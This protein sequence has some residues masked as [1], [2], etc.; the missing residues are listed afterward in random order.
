MDAAMWEHHTWF[1]D[2]AK[3][4]ALIPLSLLISCEPSFPIVG[5]KIYFLPILVL[6]SHNIFV[7]YFGNL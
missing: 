4:T 5:L 2:V 1:F 3:F 7:G 6:K